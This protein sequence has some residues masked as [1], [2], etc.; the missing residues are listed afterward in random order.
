[1]S[2]VMT[3]KSHACVGLVLT[4]RLMNVPTQVVPP[5]YSMLREEISWALEAKEPYDFTHFLILSKTY[6][7]FASAREQDENSVHKHKKQK[8]SNQQSTNEL[9]Y[10]HPED[11][12]L[13]RHATTFGRFEYRNHSSESDSKRA[14]QELGIKP[15]GHLILIEARK[16][17]DAIYAIQE[18]VGQG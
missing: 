5:M 13:E 1:M 16:L 6:Q 11:E 14:F 9:F 8:K 18:F 10:F 7:E 3:D 17:E 2:N 12:A 4:E 15:Q